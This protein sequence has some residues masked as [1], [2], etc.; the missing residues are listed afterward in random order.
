MS[1]QQDFYDFAV[2]WDCTRNLRLEAENCLVNKIEKFIYFFLQSLQQNRFSDQ[3]RKIRSALK[4]HR[5]IL[6][7]DDEQRSMKLFFLKEF[8]FFCFLLAE[9]NIPFNY[10]KKSQHEAY[11][12]RIKATKSTEF[13]PIESMECKSKSQEN[14]WS[15]KSFFACLSFK[16]TG[17][18][19]N[20][21]FFEA[22]HL[23]QTTMTLLTLH[24]L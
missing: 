23:R 2:F 18:M 16:F 1:K 7:S 20:I 5:S 13:I 21:F 12:K 24:W 19:L 15:M 17:K 22:F 14:T 8:F 9:A 11:L 6:L 10:D 4:L 3:T